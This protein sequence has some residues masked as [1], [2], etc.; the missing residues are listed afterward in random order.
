MK[1]GDIL[2]FLN[3]EVV[4]I[5]LFFIG[6]Y[7]ILARRNIVKTIVSIGIMESA[8]I[9][10]FISINYSE[11]SIPPISGI[12]NEN[13]ADPLPQALMITAIIIGVAVTAVSLTM[14]I[15]MYHKYGSTNWSKVK[16][17]RMD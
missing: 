4:S 3:G 16:R 15:S 14:F 1:A 5:I 2:E 13:I 17:K 10:F 7:G 9:L 11:D 8:V 12:A 6:V